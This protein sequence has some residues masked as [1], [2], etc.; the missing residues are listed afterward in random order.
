MIAVYS[1][2]HKQGKA[3]SIEAWHQGKLVG[4]LYGIYA[5]GMFCGESMFST[6]PNASKF[7]FINLAQELKNKNYDLIDCQL[8]T[9][10]L[11]SLGAEEIS[12]KEFLEILRV[13]S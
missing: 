9:K 2:L 1:E 3:H 12:R 7:A 5:N 6:S 11:E 8:Y 10:H 13:R 4:G